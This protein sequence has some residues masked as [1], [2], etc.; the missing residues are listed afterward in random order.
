MKLRIISDIHVNFYE[1]EL[2][3]IEKLNRYFKNIDYD[4]EILIIAGDVGIANED[5]YI[6]VLKFIRSKFKY[7]ILVPGNHEFYTHT[8][9]HKI[10]DDLANLCEK[11]GIEYLN[12][13]TVELFGYT[14]VGCTLWSDLNQK[15]WYSMNPLIYTCFKS[16][17]SFV[18]THKNHVEWLDKTLSKLNTDKVIVITHYLPSKKLIAGEF[19]QP[20]Y[21]I[22]NTAYFTDL[23]WMIQKYRNKLVYWFCGHSHITEVM[24]INKTIVYLNPMGTPGDEHKT[25]VYTGTLPIEGIK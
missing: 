12:K 17:E 24:K 4:N 25:K 16:Y 13:D 15:Y 7:I 21:A 18:S 9:Q 10:N 8:N 20:Q 19:S 14:F 3:V 1:N 5:K 6:E 23:E 2:P 11:L 22:S